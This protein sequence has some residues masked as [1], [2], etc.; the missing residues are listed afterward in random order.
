M[1]L[2]LLAAIFKVSKAKKTE[3]AY[4]EI[5]VP[6]G[7][8]AS[9]TLGDSTMVTLNSGS[10]L[11]YPERFDDS[12]R[13]VYLKGEAYFNVAKDKTKPFIV[14]TQRSRT[15]VLGTE[16]N[17]RDFASEAR[18]SIT[19]KEGSI[20]FSNKAGKKTIMLK[21]DYRAELSGTILTKNQVNV[22]SFLSWKEG[23]LHFDNISLAEAIA[24]IERVYDLKI[25]LKSSA[26]GKLRIKGSFKRMPVEKL[27]DEICFLLNTKYLIQQNTITIYK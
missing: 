13:K 10:S 19:L 12:T 26:I 11:R 25:T 17:L 20:T 6:Y 3:V 18:A 5:A 23:V 21:P 7:K 4:R 24:E 8:Q 16:F 27:M 9:V 2:F 14:E 15:R 1:G 22:D